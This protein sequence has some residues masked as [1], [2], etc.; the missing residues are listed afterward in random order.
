MIYLLA[1]LE[2]KYLVATELNLFFKLFC[3]EWKCVWVCFSVQE[4]RVSI[5]HGCVDMF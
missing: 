1:K 5:M 3:E 4:M 2:K